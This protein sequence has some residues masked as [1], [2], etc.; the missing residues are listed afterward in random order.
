[1]AISEA[2]DTVLL[3]EVRAVVKWLP[4]NDSLRDDVISDV[5][6]LIFERR[7]YLEALD[8]E[9]AIRWARGATFLIARSTRRGDFRRTAVWQRLCDVR[10]NDGDSAIADDISQDQRVALNALMVGALT[11]LDRQLLLGKIWDGYSCKTLAQQHGLTP[12]AVRI[13]LTRARKA[14]RRTVGLEKN[15]KV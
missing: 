1:M 9:H 15:G 14:C 5:G 6:L 8:V 13:R 12:N 3:R 7:T 2:L 10:E 11:D 4:V